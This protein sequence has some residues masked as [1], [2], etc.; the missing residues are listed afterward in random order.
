MP[1]AA[2]SGTKVYAFL[3]FHVRTAKLASFCDEAA[4][5][6]EAAAADPGRLRLALHQELPW[7]RA[8]SNEEFRLFMMEQVW[9]SGA[10]LE[11]HI[12][13]PHALAFNAAVLKH[14]MLVTEPSVSLFGEPLDQAQ[15]EE[16][17]AQASK[18]AEAF[19]P[20][21]EAQVRPQQVAPILQ[22]Q[23]SG[24]ALGKKVDPSNSMTSSRSSTPLQRSDSRSAVLRA[25]GAMALKK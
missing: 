17:G 10:A 22:K 5:L 21:A 7:A 24:S 18:A 11:A 6:L 4:R 1:A 20:A 2:A 14:R 25:S 12:G 15:L 19:P 8:I 3:T 13:S 23:N 9:E 16:L